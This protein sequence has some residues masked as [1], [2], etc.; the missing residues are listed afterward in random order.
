MMLRIAVVAL[1]L[2]AGV[3]AQAGL[4]HTVETAELASLGETALAGLRDV[5][6]QVSTSKTMVAGQRANVDTAKADLSATKSTLRVAKVDLKN[7]KA[8]HKE[9]S[10]G[11]DG[12]RFEAAVAALTEAEHAL[13]VVKAELKWRKVDVVLAK[14]VLKKGKAVVVRS[15]A[16]LELARL[17][18]L[19]RQMHVNVA[20]YDEA[21][22][23]A[24]QIKARDQVDKANVVVTRHAQ[25]RDQFAVQW[26]RVGGVSDGVEAVEVVDDL[27]I[28]ID[29][30]VDGI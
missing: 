5:E 11:A 4:K 14:V 29:I 22:F 24:Q 23:Q 7:A 17:D 26:E 15:E 18:L 2:S 10:A 21:S 13:A 20:S 19:K 6:H 16:D 8:E 9:A 3:N 28:D 12:D 30:D 1:A 27:D 25:K